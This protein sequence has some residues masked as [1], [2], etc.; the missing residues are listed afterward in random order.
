MYPRIAIA[1]LVF[2]SVLA[3]LATGANAQTTDP[4]AAPLPPQANRRAPAPHD[5]SWYP[6][7]QR[8]PFVGDH[9]DGIDGRDGPE[10]LHAG[11]AVFRAGS[12]P[13]MPEVLRKPLFVQGRFE[14]GY[15]LV[16]FESDVRPA[17][18]Q[19][20][21]ELTGPVRRDD[22]TA[23]SRWYV[24]NNAFVVW[25]NDLETLAHLKDAEPIDWVGRYEPGYKLDPRIGSAPLSSEHRV[26]RETWQM[27]VDLMP[28]HAL[29]DVEQAVTHLGARVLERVV[30]RGERMFDV[31]YLIVE[32][33][34][35]QIIPLAEIEGVRLL[36]ESGDGLQLHDLSAAGKIQARRL[37]KDDGV[38]SPI[39]TAADYPLWLTHDLQGQGQL[40]GVLDTSFAWANTVCGPGNAQNFG[41][42][43]DGNIDN[44]GF[45]LPVLSRV[46][47]PS[48]GAGGV[49][50]KI[51]R[52]DLLGGATLSGA[53]VEHGVNVAAAALADFYGDND[54]K[55]WEHDMDTW[56]FWGA[57]ISGLL[58]PGIAHEAQLYATPVMDGANNFRWEGPGEFETHLGTTLTR[59]AEAGVCA[60]NHSAGIVEANNTY[61][62]ISIVHDTKAFDHKWMLQCMAAG[63]DGAGT[64]TLSSQA[65]VKNAITVGA[66]DDVYFP[67]DRADFSST[68]PRFDGAIKPDVMAPGVDLFKR[69]GGSWG[70]LILAE[71]DA[72]Q[73]CPVSWAAGTS[74]SSPIIAGAAALIHQYFEEG[75]Y[76]GSE[77]L[78]DASAALMKAMLINGGHRLSGANLGDGTY[79]NGYQGWGEPNLSDVLDFGGGPRQLIVK[80]VPEEGGF[81][82]GA[83][84]KRDLHF[85]VNGASERL[86]VTLVWTDEPGTVGSGK[87]L[88]NDLDLIV[89]APDGTVYKGNVIDGAS[90]VSVSGGQR[91]SL[92]N[93]ENVILG[94]PTT[95][96]WVAS[97]DPGSGNYA[98][99]QGYALVVTGQVDEAPAPAPIA[100]FAVSATNGLAPLGVTFT[101][102]STGAFDQQSWDFGDGGTS[103]AAN[104]SHT[105][106]AA[107]TY[108]VSLSVSGPL[109]SDI[110]T[111]VGLITVDANTPQ[112]PVASFSGAPTN[113]AAPLSVGF[114]D[115]SS[116][117]VVNHSWDF[118]DGS[119][120]TA[121]NP[122]HTYT[123]PGTYNVTLTVSGPDGSDS[124]VRTG[125]VSVTPGG[126]GGTP[127]VADFSGAPTAGPAPLSVGFTDQSSGSI[128]NYSWDFGDGST[129]T[130]VSPVH[131][132]T[133]AGT[134]PVTLTVSGPDGSDTQTRTGFVTVSQGGGGGPTAPVAQF[135]G[136]PTEGPAPLFVGFNDMSTGAVSTRSWDFGDGGTSTE[137]SPL[138]QYET[139]GTYAV[140][141]TVTGPDGSDTRTE[142][143][144][145]TITSVFGPPPEAD[146]SATPVSGSAPL[147]V[148][149]QDS[150]SGAVSGWSWDF[151]DGN[152]SGEIHPTHT[153]TQPGTYSVSLSVSG[154]TG[155][156]SVTKQSLVT[157]TGGGGQA[158]VAGFTA[159]PTTGEAPHAVSFQDTS[160]G[161][162]ADRVWSFGDGKT[163][164]LEDPVHVYTS[165]GTYTV[166]LSVI[167]LDGSSDTEVRS[168]AVTVDAGPPSSSGRYYLSFNNN[169]KLPGV[170]VVRD[171]D[172][173]SYDPAT[174][175]WALY[176]DGSDVGLGNTDVD[177]L[178]VLDDGGL[179][180]SFTNGRV[181]I[182]TLYGGP[183]GS[184]TVGDEDLVWFQFLTSGEETSGYFVFYFDGSDVG[185]GGKPE[186]IDGVH[187]FANGALAISI[188][189]RGLV[190]GLPGFQ[191]EDVLLFDPVSLGAD[192]QGVWTMQFDGDQVGLS[193]RG[194]DLDGLCFE[195]GGDLLF[196]TAGNW[197]TETASGRDEDI[198]RF[199]GAYGDNT[200][201]VL[202]LELDLTLLGI[203]PRKD[204]DAL[205]FLP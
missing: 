186:D 118:G 103:T 193:G 199:I 105:Y 203:N 33:S 198:G 61:T 84:G 127:P 40:I 77:P 145:V 140:T 126:G 66:S 136:G 64:N 132:Y 102:Q 8:P 177:A 192:T 109:G 73:G 5:M 169:T 74:F 93:V 104:P 23:L 115:A 158:P 113:G 43:P 42:Y 117:A 204:V 85:Q 34:A 96:A 125:Y 7:P 162:I 82:S 148:S 62:Q 191:D 32:V 11:E 133:S 72:V 141:L 92:N 152:T 60:S 58:G 200:Q 46:L 154:P 88:I 108:T 56:G 143:D 55:W 83:D 97:V 167:G 111:K 176:F 165:P 153:Y 123:S 26:G 19:L 119:S 137:Q 47:I 122:I 57:N 1:Q 188:L 24:P 180:I 205:C 163:S 173:V 78:F 139:P 112:P 166:T 147:L 87:K 170:G 121:A 107:G 25:V 196:S 79:P 36:Q 28:G 49:N 161:A 130:A 53:G 150:T 12:P 45:A 171:E 48:V 39:V 179:L 90:G 168:D 156:H 70:G 172:V 175:T 95:G 67:E 182:P 9:L 144:F 75:R 10:V 2:G 68:G 195:P 190:D 71:N 183:E 13:A 21:D 91:D 100:N 76:P 15:F 181:D 98:V 106:S 4:S 101:N 178:H 38:N 160:T 69:S 37:N 128:T 187:E 159:T 81:L 94:N 22:G 52:A 155:T 194:E 59:M 184:T 110:E 41:S 131:T 157:V 135:I 185:L 142:V 29:D 116:G 27:H 124:Q 14:P 44:L 17:H 114:T 151:G 86:R 149:F 164:K 50:L 51:P 120:S 31:R 54:A 3:L 138:H 189:G 129:S 99:G 30:V 18:K 16:H 202:S 146:F 80:D 174:D 134:Y 35:E 89:T 20:L 201:G 63:N 197:S 6:L 65:V